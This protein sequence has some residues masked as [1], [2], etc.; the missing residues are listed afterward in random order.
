MLVVQPIG[1][2]CS[3]YERD[4]PPVLASHLERIYQSPFSAMTYFEL[5]RHAHH[6]IALVIFNGATDP[7]H[8]LMFTV[9][10]KEATLLNEL[11]TIEQQYLTYFGDFIFSRYPHVTTV[12]FNCIHGRP[13]NGSFPRYLWK[14]SQDIV[15]PLPTSPEAYNGQLGSRTRKHL[16]YYIHRLQKEFTDVTFTVSTTDSI[17]Q[18]MVENIITMNRQRMKLKHVK[19][20]YTPDFEKNIQLFSRH[21]GSVGTLRI[22]GKVIAG[23]ICYLVGDHQYLEVISHDPAYNRFNVGHIC[24]YHT[25]NHA[26]A[27]GKSAFHM[28]WGENEYKYRFGGIK[29]ELYFSSIYR[30]EYNKLLNLPKILVHSVSYLINQTHYLVTKYFFSRRK[31]AT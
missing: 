15:I 13:D 27:T 21:Y 6:P 10:G 23:S 4:I 14:C 8:V 9:T 18:S 26:I 2:Q 1:F 17:E 31:P 25:I 12:N 7:V 29:K 19:S 30:T 28:L 16:K 22:Q 11:V 3:V 5:F 20:G 24:L